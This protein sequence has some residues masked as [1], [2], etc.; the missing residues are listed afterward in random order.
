MSDWL[1]DGHNSVHNIVDSV[2]TFFGNEENRIRLGIQNQGVAPTGNGQTPSPQQL[3]VFGD[4]Y[5]NVFAPKAM[6]AN[7]AYNAWEEYS[8]RTPA[9]IVR[10]KDAEKKLKRELRTLHNILKV[11]PWVTNVDLQTMGLPIRHAPTH[12]PSP[13]PD[14]HPIAAQTSSPTPGAVVIHYHDS[15][16]GKT[17]KPKGVHGNFIRY[18][19]LDRAPTSWEELTHSV[20]STATP[21]TLHFDLSMRGKTI[22][23]TMCWENMT[24][25]YGDYGP[26]ASF[27]IG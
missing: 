27:I 3:T 22:Y 23:F 15:K 5:Y 21:I 25:Q 24:G 6:E 13:V 14:S 12:K 19:P 1:S 20:F 9:H 7:A 26:I 4:W 18:A 11:L 17:A 16:S 8:Q 2:L 10:L